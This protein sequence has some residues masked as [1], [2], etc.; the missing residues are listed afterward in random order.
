MQAIAAFLARI[1][2]RER[3]SQTRLFHLDMPNRKLTT[4]PV[5]MN[6]PRDT[7]PLK[8]TKIRRQKL[9]VLLLLTGIILLPSRL[10][11]ADCV[12]FRDG[13][14]F[15]MG[16][17]HV[18]TADLN[19]D[20]HLDVVTPSTLG[21]VWILYGDGTGHFSDPVSFPAGGYPRD[22]TVGDFNG[23]GQPD[24]AVADGFSGGAQILLN[25][26]DSTFSAPILYRTRG[27][28]S[29][30][31][32]AD[33]NQDGR[34]DL[35]L[36]ARGV[37]ILLGNGDGTFQPPLISPGT[38]S[39][40][41]IVV[42]DLDEDGDLDLAISNYGTK[43]LRIM[44]GDG[45]GHFTTAHRYLMAG[46]ASEVAIGDL[47]NDGQQ[48]LAVGVFNI[49]PDNHISVYLGNGDGS[50]TAGV[51]IPISGPHGLVAVDLDNDGDLDLATATYTEHNVTVALGDGTGEFPIVQAFFVHMG[52]G[53]PWDV[54]P[55]DFDEDGRQDLVTAGSDAH[56]AVLLGIPCR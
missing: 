28:A 52:A 49:Y 14:A 5:K 35:A 45:E 42:G 44:L 20:S 43:D 2:K 3:F 11:A 1:L 31:V 17:Y 48:D 9:P 38:V 13:G 4:L 21:V 34:L 15:Y 30:I 47:N 53:N 29:L 23:D 19:G 25:N 37:N 6:Q 22:V 46:N 8:E 12:D 27:L 32:A 33:F 18:V 10:S 24:L 51:E 56:S 39:P 16:D 41:G 40:G 7:S 50:F 55:G 54:A 36:T 26:G